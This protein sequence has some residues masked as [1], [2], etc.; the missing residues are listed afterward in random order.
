MNQ[1][2]QL[3]GQT[4]IYGLGTIVPRFL[5]Y[6]FLTPFYTRIFA[7]PDFGIYTKLYAYSAFLIVLLTFGTETSYFRF[8]KT[9]GNKKVFTNTFFFIIIT[10]LLSLLVIG[11]N[12]NSITNVLNINNASLAVW[13]VL[14]IV[15]S[16]IFMSLPFAKL[17]YENKAK[18]FSSLKIANIVLNIGFNVFFFF[19]LP[20]LTHIA[21]FNSIYFP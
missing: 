11:S 9:H 20:H 6:L 14:G 5:N 3:A 18:L 1:I 7:E 4:L 10:G 15:L 8:A 13:L 19:I 21:L 12:V 2:K 16:D 17:R